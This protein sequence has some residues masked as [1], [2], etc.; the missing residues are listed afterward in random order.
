M[1]ETNKHGAQDYEHVY[2][3]YGDA[4]AL[5]DHAIEPTALQSAAAAHQAAQDRRLDALETTVAHLE[6]TVHQLLNQEGEL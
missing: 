2:P 1:S 4:A 5:L 3:P 6:R